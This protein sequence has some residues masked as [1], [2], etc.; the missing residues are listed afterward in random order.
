MKDKLLEK[1]SNPF[2]E[3]IS[4]NMNAEVFM[5][6]KPEVVDQI[7]NSIRN[8]RDILIQNYPH[9]KIRLILNPSSGKL[10]RMG[11]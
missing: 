9:L 5:K 3:L 4:L 2:N 8:E 6:L 7:N 1:N 11:T 10:M